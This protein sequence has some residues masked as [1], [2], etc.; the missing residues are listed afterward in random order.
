MAQRSTAQIDKVEDG[1]LERNKD[2]RDV[3]KKREKAVNVGNTCL[4]YT[5][6]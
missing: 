2:T 4:N 5:H 3:I 1:S 6:M